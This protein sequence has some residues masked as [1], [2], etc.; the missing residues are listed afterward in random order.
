MLAVTV[1]AICADTNVCTV[2]HESNESLHY[3]DIRAPMF[4]GTYTKLQ[5]YVVSRSKSFSLPSLSISLSL[6]LIKFPSVI[7][8]PSIN[9]TKQTE[10]CIKLI[11]HARNTRENETRWRFICCTGKCIFI[12]CNINYIHIIFM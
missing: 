4:V 7:N 5:T 8:V 1:I 12:V 10:F 11:N 2:S 9:I 6:S 3:H